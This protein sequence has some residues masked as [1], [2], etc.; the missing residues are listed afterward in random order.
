MRF[1]KAA[2][3]LVAVAALAACAA[4][5]IAPG[6]LTG[7][8]TVGIVSLVG[9]EVEFKNVGFTVF[10]N[11]FKKIKLPELRLDDF[12][13]ERLTKLLAGRYEIRQV[14]YDPKSFP[15]DVIWDRS[16]PG[17]LSDAKPGGEVIRSHVSPRGLDAY[18]A[19]VK[20]AT[21]IAMSNQA[22]EGVG[23]FRGSGLFSSDVWAHALYQVVVYDGKSYEPIGAMLAQMP[24]LGFAPA[25]HGP[26]K[27]VDET[28]W[29]DSPDSLSAEQKEL[30]RKAFEDL[31]DRSLSETLRRLKLLP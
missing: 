9:D 27:E 3:T 11:T 12:I 4:Q 10:G 25:I 29:S 31:I 14:T 15:Q 19:V 17:P 16:D 8:R 20:Y 13:V 24:G 7:I 21:G 23:I 2:L 5:P 28:Y 18:I 30:L 6:K 1:V 22:V 26:S